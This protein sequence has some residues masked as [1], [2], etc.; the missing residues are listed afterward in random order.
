MLEYYLLDIFL[1]FFDDV[2]T[3][4]SDKCIFCVCADDD[5]GENSMRINFIFFTWFVGWL[6][7]GTERFKT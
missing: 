6:N 2:N 4:P 7:I 3:A 5:N 1:Y